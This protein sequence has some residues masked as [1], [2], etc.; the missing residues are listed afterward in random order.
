ME[1]LAEFA[2]LSFT[3]GCSCLAEVKCSSEMVAKGNYGVKSVF[4]TRLASFQ[5]AH[6]GKPAQKQN[7]FPNLSPNTMHSF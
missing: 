4:R 6:F 2:L 5:V 1:T 3:L 7:E